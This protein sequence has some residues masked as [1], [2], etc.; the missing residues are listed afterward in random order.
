MP[1]MRP[2]AHALWGAWRATSSIDSLLAPWRR[3]CWVPASCAG[4][5]VPSFNPGCAIF[6]SWQVMET[7]RRLMG[8]APGQGSSAIEQVFGLK[9]RWPFGFCCI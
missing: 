7:E 2:C 1:R 9:V 4:W 6:Q 5:S 3:H 8:A